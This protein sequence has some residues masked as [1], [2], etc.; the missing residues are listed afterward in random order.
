MEIIIHIV[1]ILINIAILTG[2]GIIIQTV[3]KTQNKS[4]SYIR[5]VS[6]KD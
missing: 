4:D 5:R 3:C 1:N 6:F 2:L